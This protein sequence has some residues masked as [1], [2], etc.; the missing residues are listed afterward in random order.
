MTSKAQNT[1]IIRCGYV[2]PNDAS[3]TRL[4]PGVYSLNKRSNVPFVGLR[5]SAGFQKQISWGEVAE[6]PCGELVTVINNSYH[7][8]DIFISKGPD[9]NNRPSRIT[10]PVMFQNVGFTE[11][12]G[13]NVA[14]ASVF[15]CDTRGA[16][17]A[18]V[19]IDA[20]SVP[21]NPFLTVFI[22]GRRLD[23]SMK[24]NNSLSQFPA[25]WGPGVGFLSAL[26]VGPSTVLS[27]IP[28][29]LNGVMSDDTRPHTLL[30]AGDVFM[31]IGPGGILSDVIDWP[32]S[33][34]ISEFPDEN[35]PFPG[36][37]YTIEYD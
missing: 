19:N 33:K 28:L 29:S 11:E 6:V 20:F 13:P 23:G 18:Y 16:K 26:Q 8:G 10:V 34:G 25:P 12:G 30:D 22:R 35:V 4:G 2:D 1:T 15:P 17:R 7:G 14:W 36:I 27:N 3:D 37:W 5:G 21:E 9:V 32:A 31:V 24:T